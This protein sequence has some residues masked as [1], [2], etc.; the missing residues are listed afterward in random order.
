MVIFDIPYIQMYDILQLFK[1]CQIYGL[2]K[3]PFIGIWSRILHVI[4]LS[5]L[6]II[7]NLIEFLLVEKLSLYNW[8]K[9]V[10][11]QVGA[12]LLQLRVKDTKTLIVAALSYPLK[13]HH[14][15]NI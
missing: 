1:N 9:C 8:E 14:K 7:L 15:S 11:K 3:T 12:G 10:A 2:K 6:L 5:I 4:L 13:I